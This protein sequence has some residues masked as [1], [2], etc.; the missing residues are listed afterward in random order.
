MW[1]DSPFGEDS[2]FGSNEILLDSPLA[3]DPPYVQ[4]GRNLPYT[5]IDQEPMGRGWTPNRYPGTYDYRTPGMPMNSHGEPYQ[6][7]MPPNY[8]RGMAPIQGMEA[9]YYPDAR[10]QAKFEQTYYNRDTSRDFQHPMVDRRQPG[11][12]AP[13]ATVTSDKTGRAVENPSGLGKLTEHFGISADNFSMPKQENLVL[14]LLFML[15]CIIA[16]VIQSYQNR[17]ERAEL[18]SML[19][20]MSNKSANVVSV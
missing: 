19:S 1:D 2:R 5:P 14:I 12:G 8:G 16:L 7:G 13:L 6:S 3:N 11:A 20:K 17:C 9:P 15:F 10:G 4:N 18:M